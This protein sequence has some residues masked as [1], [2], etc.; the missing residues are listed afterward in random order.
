MYMNR[1][2]GFCML[3]VLSACGGGIIGPGDTWHSEYGTL[4]TGAPTAMQYGAYSTN[5]TTTHR[6]AV[7]LPLSGDNAAAGRAI[8]TS[9]EGAILS[10]APQNLSVTFYDTATNPSDAIDAALDTHPS[11]IVG[12]VFANN[13]RILRE[14]K[15]ENVPALAFTSDESAIG[16]GVMTMNLMPNNSVEVIVQ[17]M[18]RD[19]VKSFIIIAPDTESGKIMAG[20]AR[21]AATIYDIP[22]SGVFYYTES[23]PDSIKNTIATATM[24]AARTSAN[25]RA[26]A[27][28][29]DILTNETLTAVERSSL[30]RQLDIRSKSD[31]LGNVPY[32]AVL[33]LGNADDTKSLASFMRYYGVGARD[34]RFYGTALWDGTNIASDLTMSGAK[35]AAMP[36][37]SPEFIA[38]YERISGATPSRLASFGYDAANMAMGMLYSS[39]SDAAY[40]L[41]P[42]G[43]IGSSG[44]IRLKPAGMSERALRIVRLSGD[45]TVRTVRN[46][47]ENFITPIYNIEQRHITPATPMELESPGIN[48]LSYIDIPERFRGKYKSKTYGA[49]MTTQ[50]PATPAQPVVTILPEDDRDPIATP[51]FTPVKLESVGRT[52]IDSIEIYE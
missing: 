11:V 9:I 35:Y 2:F 45:G 26:R 21:N 52:Y 15:P 25:N 3:G 12:P 43:Y 47:P 27:I 51:D 19:H 4:S 1:F 28:L 5:D 39:K 18:Q 10:R 32:D 24:N 33:F 16:D 49:H 41:D 23:D 29:S 13:A 37:M 31:T 48:P 38:K 40:L 30:N 50:K 44:L 34:A 14:S 42:S 20:A 17:E 6:M 22:T 46:A 36:D 8:Q 7:L